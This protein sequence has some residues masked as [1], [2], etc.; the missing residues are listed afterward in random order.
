MEGLDDLPADGPEGCQDL[1]ARLRAAATN[2]SE[3][4]TAGAPRR[5]QGQSC[6]SSPW[7]T[8]GPSGLLGPG[9]WPG[10]SIETATALACPAGPDRV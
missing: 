1:A 5:M 7:A 10:A 4:T 3:R 9:V 6:C 2:P 8:T